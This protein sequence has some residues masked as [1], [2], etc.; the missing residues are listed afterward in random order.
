VH[1]HCTSII[2]LQCTYSVSNVADL[3]QIKVLSTYIFS[4]SILN[5]QQQQVESVITLD[6]N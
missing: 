5:R 3:L 4:S 2:G 6:E 1:I